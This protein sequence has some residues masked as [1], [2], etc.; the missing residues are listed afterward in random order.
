MWL[1]LYLKSQTYTIVQYI[2]TSFE[3][4]LFCYAENSSDAS[5]IIMETVIYFIFQDLAVNRMFKRTEFIWNRI[6]CN[7]INVF[8]ATWS[9]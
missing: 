5:K 3:R 2:G 4:S 8:T 6:F 1:V 7:I 9:I